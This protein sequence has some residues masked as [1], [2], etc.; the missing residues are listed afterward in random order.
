M[1]FGISCNVESEEALHL[2]KKV[3]HYLSE[4]H[5][6]LLENSLAKKLRR[7][8]LPLEKMKVDALVTIGGDGTIL[9]ALQR[10]DSKILGIN[11]GVLGFL[12]EIKAEDIEASLERVVKGDYT[13]E[14]RL[15]LRTL[16]NEKRFY[17]CT[18]EAVVHTAAVAKMRRFKV[19]V[20]GHSAED[21]RA[22]GIIVA[23]PTGSTCYAM[24]V[25]G[26]IIDPRVEAIVVV[27]IAPFKLPVR[28]MVVPANSEIEITLPEPR[29]CI[30]VLDGQY[31]V[32]LSGNEV[33][34]FTIS[35]KKAKFVRFDADFYRKIQE[36]LAV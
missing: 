35:D 25:G 18:N 12:A 5:E 15:K 14:E 8:G 34:R 11:I 9:R 23:T 10:N 24:S 3:L 28:P 17:D 16:V 6:V 21:I 26:P 4:K 20:D 36:K 22:D 13:T 2:S 7:K 32:E 33:M 19:R 27:A 1:K 29:P 30:L 31:E